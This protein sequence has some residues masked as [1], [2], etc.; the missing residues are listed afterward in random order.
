MRPKERGSTTRRLGHGAC[1][2]K[3]DAWPKLDS[4][5]DVCSSR[6]SW[7]GRSSRSRCRSR[8]D[9]EESAG[10][11]SSG[12]LASSQSSKAALQLLTLSDS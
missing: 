10:R 3:D 12:S 9:G 1:H 6:S 8:S 4:F 11:G 5:F 2:G 7:S